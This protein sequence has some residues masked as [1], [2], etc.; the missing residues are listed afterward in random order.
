[1]LTYHKLCE[2]G[3]ELIFAGDGLRGCHGLQRQ[4][5][6]I[7][8]HAVDL[9]RR[10]FLQQIKYRPLKEN[11][12]LIST[13]ELN[14]QYKTRQERR[15]QSHERINMSYESI[16]INHIIF[17]LSCMLYLF[18]FF[19]SCYLQSTQKKSKDSIDLKIVLINQVFIKVQIAP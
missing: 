13:I 18:S 11:N 10:L 16:L 3:V 17:I 2:L 9:R 12:H 1:M 8:Y 6:R 14:N 15:H 5:S 19:V 7:A 4:G